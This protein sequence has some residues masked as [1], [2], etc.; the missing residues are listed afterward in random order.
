[1]SIIF[2]LILGGS[3][4]VLTL[5]VLQ[6]IFLKA[7]WEYSIYFLLL[8]LPIYITI[9]SLTLQATN[10]ILLVKFFQILKELVVVCSVLGFLVYQKNVLEYPFRLH[11]VDKLFLAFVGLAMLYLFLPIGAPFLNKAL[12][13]KS[14]LIPGFVYF[15]GRNTNFSDLEVNRVFQLI[16]FVTIA[17]FV[18]N[19]FEKSIDTHLQS[20][21]GYAN[22]NAVISDIEPAGHFGLTWTFETQAVT[23][24]LASFY[25]DPL[26]LASSVLMGFSAGLIWFLTSKREKW[27]LYTVV[28]FCAM[29]GLF[30]SASRAAFAAFFL[31]VFFIALIFKLN[32]LIVSGVLLAVCFSAYILFFATDD[33]YYYVLDTLTFENTSS[34]G[35]VIEWL[36]ALDSMVANPLGIGLAMSGN[37]GSVEDELRIGGENQFLIFGVQLGW[38]G[39]LLYILL[40]A[41]SIRYSLKVFNQTPNTMTARIAFVAATVKFGLLLPLFTANVEIYTYVSWVTWWMVGYSIREYQA[42]NTHQPTLAI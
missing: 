1:M 21:T 29:M 3:F 25:A 18:V 31:M 14:I 13:M 22:Y 28:M 16:F 20:L 12:Y 42:L 10:S 39:M 17:A 5:I 30:F 41:Y 36:L 23:K 9:L 15:I 6:Q 27:F 24:R 32:K 4:V 7:K 34:M 38:I 37:F 35:H 40:L 19:I 8:Y 2:F 11:L 33:L 26:E